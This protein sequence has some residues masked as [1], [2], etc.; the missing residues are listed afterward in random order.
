M[1]N[2]DRRLRAL[3]QLKRLREME[4]LDALRTLGDAQAEEVRLARL[5]DRTRLLA[6]NEEGRAASHQA[7]GLRSH[8]NVSAAM[9]RLSFETDR[10]KDHAEGRARAARALLRQ[11]EH[12]LE[13]AELG[14][15][16]QGREIARRAD[17]R[18]ASEA[19]RKLA[20]SLRNS[21]ATGARNSTRGRNSPDTA[22]QGDR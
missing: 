10:L 3:S 18:S 14:I 20:R 16:Q 2:E 22:Q 9:T 5:T 13:R 19:P 4:R 6:R 12:R 21:S 1:R 8:M 7:D 15:T 17:A 11:A